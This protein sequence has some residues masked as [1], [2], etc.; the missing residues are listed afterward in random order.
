[1]ALLALG[2]SSCKQEDDP[3]YRVP[4]TFTISEPALKNQVFET[5]TEMTSTETVNLFCTQPDYGYSAVCNY[6]AIMSLNPECPVAENAAVDGESIALENLTPT[7]AAMSIKT[8][9]IGAG[10]CKLAGFTSQEDYDKSDFGKTPQKIYFRAVCEIPGIE[11][12]RIV[13]SNVVSY[14]AVMVR[15]AEK[16]PGWIYIVGNVT[17]L[18]TGVADDFKGPSAAN[19]DHYYNNFRMLEPENKI[20]EKLYVGQFGIN[21]KTEDPAETYENNCSQFR[22]FTALTGWSTESSV[23]SNEADFYSLSITDKWEAGYDGKMVDHGL[24][25]WG[26]WLCDKSGPQPATIV[27]DILDMKIY[28]KEGLHNVT[29]T[30][31][32]PSF[33]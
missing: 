27:A 6:S 12:S 17:N 13:S 9:E 7:S 4:T 15:Y 5:E 23:G 26:I 21:P 16:K 24:G 10:A 14:D 1:M 19:Y 32:T 22:F 33:E 2:V 25:N 28:V 11:G 30:G 8:F 20:G 3:K 18:E 29:F 31:R